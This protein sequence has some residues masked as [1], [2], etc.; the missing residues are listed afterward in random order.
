MSVRR[1]WKKL[2]CN[3][4]ETSS[5]YQS[6]WVNAAVKKRMLIYGIPGG[7]S[8]RYLELQ[9]DGKT[10]MILPVC[11]YRRSNRYCSVGS[12]NGYQVYDFIYS[13]EMTHEKMKQGLLFALKKLKV[14]QLSL[15]NVPNTSVLYA[16]LRELETCEDYQLTWESNDNVCIDT[17][18][19]YDAWHSKL[20][21]S[22]RQNLRTAYNR[23]N[24]DGVSMR[25][26]IRRG[27]KMKSDTLNEIIELY[28]ERHSARYNVETSTLKK[29]YL[30]YLDFS[31]A[32]LRSHPDNFLRW[33]T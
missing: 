13:R 31:T 6:Y 15:R 16:C 23:M 19:D 3:A 18:L 2:E 29:Q 14:E 4:N 24:T 1:T 5:V 8:A 26:K 9:E 30:K 10:L 20:S 12:F 22:N 21:K 11:K 33:S 32:C 27:E 17:E 7:Y 28:R 25:F